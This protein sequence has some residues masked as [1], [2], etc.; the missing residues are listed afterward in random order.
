[1]YILSEFSLQGGFFVHL[2]LKFVVYILCEF[3]FQI[4]V[5][6]FLVFALD[7]FFFLRISIKIY[8][9]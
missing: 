3:F 9:T 8:A 4:S 7:Y 6:G 1:M 2:V 5:C